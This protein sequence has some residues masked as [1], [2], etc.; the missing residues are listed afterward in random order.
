MHI[1]NVGERLVLHTLLVSEAF[2][3]VIV[4]QACRLQMGIKRSRAQE[5]ESLAFHVLCYGI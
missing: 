4:Y 1:E 5:L 2:Y 3:N